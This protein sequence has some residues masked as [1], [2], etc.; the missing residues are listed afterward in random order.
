[1]IS[2]YLLHARKLIYVIIFGALVWFISFTIF[3]E[4]QIIKISVGDV[5]PV[6]FTAPNYIE[7]IDE[8]QT[9]LNKAFAV[10]SVNPIYSIDTTINDAVI[11]GVK[12]MFLAVIEARV[13]ETLIVNDSDI[14]TENTEPEVEIKN[15]TKLEQIKKITES[16]LFSTI[17]TSTIEVLV[18]ISNYDLN[19]KS[20]YLSQLELEAKSQASDILNNGINN[21]NLNGLRQSIVSN[22]PYLDLTSD[23]FLLIPENRLRSTVSEI[24][25]EN[26]VSNQK[27]EEDLWNNQKQQISDSVEPVVIKFFENDLIIQEGTI[28]NQI[29]YN[30]LDSFGYLSGESRTI[31]TAALPIIFSIFLLIYFLFWRF[32]DSIWNNDKEFLLL[33]TLILIA[34]VFLRG[35]SYFSQ[36]LELDYLKYGV[37][38]SF[39]GVV[40]A[41]LLN[42]RA[43]LVLSLSSALLALAGGGNI[44]LLALG[45]ILSILPSVFISEDIDRRLLR[46]RII[47]ISLTQP[48]I[49][50]GI[51]FFLRE[52]FSLFE[53]LITG[54]IGGLVANL[55]AFS[56]ITYI[57]AVFKITTN[58]RLSELA[59]R[60]H[61]GLRYLEEKALGTFNHSL[62]VGTLADRASNVINA[63]AQLAR[64]MAYFHD[65]GKTEHPTMFI[66]NQFGSSNPHDTLSTSESSN[67]IRAHVTD[68][69]KLAKKFKIPEVVYN[70]ILE[71]HG[72]SVMRFF[73]E[74][75]KIDNPDI[76]KSDFRHLGRKPTS[77]ETTILMFADALEGACRARFLNEDADE[78]KIR[79]VIEEIFNEKISDGQLENSPIT[80]SDID[81]IK[82]SFQKSLEG[83]YHQRV[84]YPDISEEE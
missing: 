7:V 54:L 60:N 36:T 55:A 44:G 68:G 20:N 21:E 13:S 10:E 43:S 46:E 15:L 27:L 74:K 38:I 26:L 72:D 33:L 32:N 51:Y 3:P 29:Q 71:H 28:V 23:L 78:E 53:V 31:Q 19:N 56:L 70:G 84:M 76:D 35:T 5:S 62:V 22:P 17:S 48:V 14:V 49:S 2:N 81:K 82:Q 11:N 50:F 39:V 25:A 73:Y 9:A 80:F 63:N 4:N 37:P 65:L 16:L 45:G 24:I 34:S 1:M 61:P 40:S 79:D 47:Y 59:D 41:T 8:E 66:E 52:D 58:F 67:I 18:E 77:K 42:L 6:S 30:T 83:L 69:V 57:E 12:D 75:E 64:A